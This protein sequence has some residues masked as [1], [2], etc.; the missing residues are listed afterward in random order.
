MVVLSYVLGHANPLLMLPDM[1]F[2]SEFFSCVVL[3]CACSLSP[4][5]DYYHNVWVRCAWFVGV[6]LQR[7]FIFALDGCPQGFACPGW[8]FSYLLVWDSGPMWRVFIWTPYLYVAQTRT[9]RPHRL[10]ASLLL[11]QPP[12]EALSFPFHKAGRAYVEVLASH[13]I[14]TDYHLITISGDHWDFMILVPLF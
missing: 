11:T 8:I 5:W 12:W 4:S 14:W 3:I 6:Y 7:G 1:S 13:F 9:Y 10:D 2:C